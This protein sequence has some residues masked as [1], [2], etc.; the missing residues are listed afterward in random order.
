MAGGWVSVPNGG[1]GIGPGYWQ[2]S[3]VGCQK[4]ARQLEAEGHDHDCCGLPRHDVAH[5]LVARPPEPLPM[6]LSEMW[7]RRTRFRYGRRR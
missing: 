1:A 4:K 6:T 3:H 7:S 5:E 2:C